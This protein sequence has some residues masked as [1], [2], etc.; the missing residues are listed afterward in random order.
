MDHQR[1]NQ[2][3]NLSVPW[4]FKYTQSINQPSNKILDQLKVLADTITSLLCSSPMVGRF[5]RRIFTSLW[6]FGEERLS[7]ASVLSGVILWT[8]KWSSSSVPK[9]WACATAPNTTLAISL[10]KQLFL[11]INSKSFF[12]MHAVYTERMEKKLF[13]YFAVKLNSL[14]KKMSNFFVVFN[15]YPI[16]HQ[17]IKNNRLPNFI[18]SINQSTINQSINQSINR[19]NNQS[20]NQSIDNQSI[21][22]SSNQSTIN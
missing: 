18:S 21:N 10:W 12:T 14:R 4:H 16:F 8:L 15:I 2:S 9:T 13:S 17:N 1:I 3:I 5:F 19:S 6:S 22:Q 20:T 11:S 7:N